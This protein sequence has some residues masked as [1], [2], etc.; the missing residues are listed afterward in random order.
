M[1]NMM[2]APASLAH[3]IFAGLLLACCL[4]QSAQASCANAD[5]DADALIAKWNERVATSKLGPAWHLEKYNGLGFIRQNLGDP[6]LLLT[7][8]V[9][10]GRCVTRLDIKS[11]RADADGYAVLVACMSAIIV[12]NPTLSKDQRKAVLFAALGLDKPAPGRSYV[13][14]HVNYE[15][16]KNDEINDFSAAP[17]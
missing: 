7:A 10:K 11:R 2:K 4:T 6:S 3:C 1:V 5:F 13:A 8:K 17:E 14:N 12:T 16:V 9:D 15:F